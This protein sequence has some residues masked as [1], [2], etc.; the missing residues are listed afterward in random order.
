MICDRLTYLVKCFPEDLKAAKVV[1]N[2][3]SGEKSNCENYTPISVLS[4]VSKIFEWVVFEKLFKFMQVNNLFYCRQF[5]FRSKMSTLQ[6]L[7]DKTEMIRNNTHLEVFCMLLDL[8]KAFYAIYDNN[9]KLKL[10]SYCVRGICLAWF[11][12]Y[13]NDRTQCV[14]INHQYSNTLAAECGV[15]QGSIIG[16]LMFLIHVNDFPS[17]CDGIVPFLYADDTNCVYIRPKNATLQDKVEHIPSWMA[18]NRVSLDIGK[19]ELLH[20]LSCLDENVKMG[21]TTI[22]PTKSVTY[23][24]VH[25]DKNLTFEAHVQSVLG[26][27]AK[28]VSVVMLLRRFCKSSIVVRYYDIYVK[29]IIQYGLLVCG[30]TRKNKLETYFCCKRKCCKLSSSKTEDI[31]PTS[32]SNE[33]VQ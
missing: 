14:A 17:T 7:A 9:L 4:V 3:T 19:A 10:E 28:H 11:R 32:C 21:N 18:K 22:S 16:P 27:M 15:P 29:P 13:L 23:V 6:A 24:G 33:A 8:G 30:C 25:L 20:F 5:G 1:P 26:K 31:R 2:S 12:S